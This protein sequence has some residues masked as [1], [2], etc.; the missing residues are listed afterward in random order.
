M[1]TKQNASIKILWNYTPILLCIPEMCWSVWKFY[2]ILY[3]ICMMDNIFADNQ[4]MNYIPGSLHFIWRTVTFYNCCTHSDFINFSCLWL[5]YFCN[6]FLCA[7]IGSIAPKGECTTNEQ[8]ADQLACIEGTC[9][10]P[11]TKLPCGANAYCESEKHAAWCRCTVGFTEG[12]NGECVSGKKRNHLS[13][14]DHSDFICMELCSLDGCLNL[15]I[16]G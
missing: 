2:G 4:Y 11:C 6:S 13:W 1:I 3:G 5:L 14:V 9:I 10:N 8:C 7:G 15:K 12:A 16:L